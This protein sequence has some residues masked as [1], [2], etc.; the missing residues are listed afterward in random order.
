MRLVKTLR[1]RARLHVAAWRRRGCEDPPEQ[2]N[3]Q[4]LGMPAGEGLECEYLR[5][6]EHQLGRWGITARCRTIEIRV[7]GHD[8][9]RDV[10][11]AFIHLVEWDHNAAIRLLMGLP[12]LDAKI[13]KAVRGLWLADVSYFDGL[14]LHVAPHVH[15]SEGMA[16][17]RQLLV[18]TTGPRNTYGPR[19]KLAADI[20]L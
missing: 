14:M 10:F 3:Y 5:L 12:L 1:W 2:T 9:G 11:V 8:R 20:S 16:D 6:V 13:R 7:V 19:R 18:S 17:L 4:A 15:E